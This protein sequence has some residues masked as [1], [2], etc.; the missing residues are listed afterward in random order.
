MNEKNEKTAH[1]SLVHSPSAATVV[2]V[3]P[4]R[5]ENR[6]WL[7]RRRNERQRLSRLRTSSTSSRNTV[8]GSA[9]RSRSENAP[10]LQ[11]QPDP[12]RHVR[13]RGRHPCCERGRRQGVRRR[14]VGRRS[15]ATLRVPRG[16]YRR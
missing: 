4:P 9:G 11:G 13:G 7:R 6:I 2:L 16:D 1:L 8:P 5:N 12:H 15:S 3:L 14:P 10:E